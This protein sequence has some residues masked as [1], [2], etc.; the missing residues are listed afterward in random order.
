MVNPTLYTVQYYTTQNMNVSCIGLTG[1]MVTVYSCQMAMVSGWKETEPDLSE[2]LCF[3]WVIATSAW[4]NGSRRKRTRKPLPPPIPTN[5]PPT[6]W[7]KAAQCGSSVLAR[8]D[9]ASAIQDSASS[10]S[11]SATRRP[12]GS[13]DS[14]REFPVPE[15]N[16]RTW[17]QKNSTT[18][19]RIIM[20]IKRIIQESDRHIQEQHPLVVVADYQLSVPHTSDNNYSWIRQLQRHSYS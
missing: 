14:E 8:E 12:C 10:G 6:P 2:R 20:R 16:R 5:A 11:A 9:P 19:P 17:N 4:A 7:K 3:R 15:M 1:N 13:S 18:K